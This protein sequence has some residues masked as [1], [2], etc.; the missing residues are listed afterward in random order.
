M[1][2]IGRRSFFLKSDSSYINCRNCFRPRDS[3]ECRP[4]QDASIIILPYNWK[5]RKK[6]K[7]SLLKITF[8][9]I[10]ETCKYCLQ[11]GQNEK[12]YKNISFLYT[13]LCWMRLVNVS[14][15]RIRRISRC[16]LS[17]YVEKAWLINNHVERLEQR[18]L[19]WHHWY[20]PPFPSYIPFWNSLFR[21]QNTSSRRTG[22]GSH[23]VTHCVLRNA[24][25]K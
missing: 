14:P 7:R 9:S 6:E 18:Y 25:A 22:A 19:L 21:G 13:I 24:S 16:R 10:T 17:K 15:F 4:I 1:F 20:P 3:H 12:S 23:S 8:Y 5:E 11:M 2:T